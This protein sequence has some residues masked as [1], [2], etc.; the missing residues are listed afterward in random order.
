MRCALLGPR[1]ACPGL[2]TPAGEQAWLGLWLLCRAPLPFV[3]T[4]PMAPGKGERYVPEASPG[5][6]VLCAQAIGS[7]NSPQCERP[8]K[9]S[10]G[11]ELLWLTFF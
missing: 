3:G 7:L 4:F 5:Q 1:R 10:Y 2:N 11:S 6:R 8:V 9:G